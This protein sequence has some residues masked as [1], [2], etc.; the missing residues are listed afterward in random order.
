MPTDL[1]VIS[2]E[3]NAEITSWIADT[4]QYSLDDVSR[5]IVPAHCVNSNCHHDRRLPS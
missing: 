5:G 1:R 4:R 3:Q 2:C